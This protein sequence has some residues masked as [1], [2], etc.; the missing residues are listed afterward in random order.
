MNRVL[1]RALLVTLHPAH[2]QRIRLSH[3]QEHLHRFVD[4]S[5]LTI[6][7]RQ[8]NLRTRIGREEKKDQCSAEGDSTKGAQERKE[9]LHKDRLWV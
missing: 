7:I 4:I 9:E 5:G 1:E 3:D 6:G 8:N 2:L